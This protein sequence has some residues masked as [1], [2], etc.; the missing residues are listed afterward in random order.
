VRWLHL[1]DLHVGR[2]NISQRTALSAL[3]AAVEKQA[4]GTPPFDLILLTG[5]L[6]FSGKSDEYLRIEQ[7]VISP[8]RDI[9]AFASAKI[10]AVPGNHD[11]DCD[12]GLP[13][14][15]ETLGAKRQQEFFSSS[16]DGIRLRS[17]R[18]AAF[19]EYE[20]FTKRTGILTCAPAQSVA[21]HFSLKD[22]FG[23][24]VDVICVNTAFFSDKD[25]SD[26][27]I[28]QAPVEALREAFSVCKNPQPALVI[29]H[30]PLNWFT[31]D[32]SHHLRTLLIEHNAIYL[33]GHLHEID[34][35]FGMKGLVSL[36][37]GAVYQA[38]LSSAAKPYYRNSFALCQLNEQLELTFIS[39][40]FDYGAWV[41]E[42]HLPPDI[43][44]G[45]ASGT[46]PYRLELARTR[47]IE[48]RRSPGRPSVL[49]NA[50]LKVRITAPM[51]IEGDLTH[52]WQR[53]LEQLGALK[54]VT[55]VNTIGSRDNQ[56]GSVQFVARDRDG[57]HLITAF[58]ASSA[59][60]TYS[61]IE[62]TNTLLDTESLDSCILATFGQLAEEATALSARLKDKKALVVLTGV[63]IANLAGKLTI[64]RAI[65]D[66]DL[67]DFDSALFTPLVVSDGLAM[68]VRDAVADKWFCVFDPHGTLAKGSDAITH[69]V[70]MAT[71]EL[72][73]AVYWASEPGGGDTT[74]GESAFDRPAYLEQS[75]LLF[76]TVRYAGLAALGLHL[77]VDSLRKI[78]VP[79]AADVAT[80][81]ASQQALKTAV[82]DFIEALKLDG[83]QREQLEMQLGGYYGVG[84][85]AEAGAATAL[86]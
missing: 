65:R 61:T 10:L 74:E 49:G 11:L 75:A 83:G 51:W 3:V 71:P 84:R 9:P 35:N 60:L 5:D 68:L 73:N 21:E 54:S 45:S 26:E 24:D 31:R 19:A 20:L 46:A 52:G 76:D 67:F 27:K 1:S 33:H 48:A 32:S 41:L 8:L 77:P 23:A 80:D 63:D 25:V 34:P 42:T 82:D 81:S 66:K 56:D 47:M 36:G 6:A 7:S 72:A 12:I 14:S 30:H 17:Q 44:A 40:D 64:I 55:A 4:S 86:Y 2:D 22:Q 69:Q 16:T 85:S 28:S 38:P 29:G 15:W 37:F 13:I 59:V 43:L 70:R 53:L 57:K 62:Q 50:A 18:A 79:A 78:Y 39:W 58:S